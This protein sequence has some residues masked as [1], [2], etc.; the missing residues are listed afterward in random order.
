MFE[1]RAKIMNLDKEEQK[2]KILKENSVGTYIKQLAY[3][4]DFPSRNHSASFTTVPCTMSTHNHRRLRRMSLDRA[5]QRRSPPPAWPKAP[6]LLPPAWA[7]YSIGITGVWWDPSDSDESPSSRHV[8]F[9]SPPPRP[10]S[11]LCHVPA[12]PAGAG[13]PELHSRLK[14]KKRDFGRQ[15]RRR[16]KQRWKEMSRLKFFLSILEIWFSLFLT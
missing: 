6:P 12:S 16:R 15:W 7:S 10:I 4:S 9:G 3:A 11:E 14:E 5:T 13:F 8:S 2:Q 1:T